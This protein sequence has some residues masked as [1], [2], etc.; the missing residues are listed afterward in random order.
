MKT[1]ETLIHFDIASF[2]I[3]AI[4]LFQTFYRKMS[5]GTT[6][7]IFVLMICT[8]LCAAFFEITL[9]FLRSFGPP[10]DKVL[11]IVKSLY[12]LC[13]NFATPVYLMYVI[14]LTRTWHRFG[15]RPIGLAMFAV[16][17]IVDIVLIIINLFTGFMFHYEDNVEIKHSMLPLYVCAIIY[18]SF[19][20]GYVIYHN[21]LLKKHEIYALASMLP[22]CIAAVIVKNFY[23]NSLVEIFSNTL[24]ILIM[25]MSI[26]RPEH[27]IDS[28]TQLRKYNAY[29]DDMKKNFANNNHFTVILVNIANYSSIHHILGYDGT[30]ELLVGIADKLNKANEKTKA[31]AEIYYLDRGRY[32]VSVNSFN[33]EKV[34]A[35]AEEVNSIFKEKVNINHVAIDLKDHV[36]V[37]RCP[38]DI[39]DFRALMSF[40]NDFHRK[41]SYTGDVIYAEELFKQKDFALYNELD[42]IIDRAIDNNSLK[43]YYQPIYSIKEK[44]FVSAE[45][46]I[47][48]IDKK[49]GFVPPDIFIP[50]AENNGAIHKIGSFVLDQVCSFIASDEFRRLGLEYIEINLSVAQCMQEGLA[51]EVID[52]LQRYNLSPSQINLEITETAASYNQTTMTENLDKLYSA[53]ISFSLDDFG[54][55][56]SNMDRVASLPI[57]IVKLDRSFVNSQH[58]PKTKIFLEHII[59]MFKDMELEIVVEGIESQKMVE[60]F[61]ELE[62]DFIQGYY[63]S[64][65]IPKDEFISF[66]E[67][68]IRNAQ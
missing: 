21:K 47:R 28:F 14:S 30:K 27:I 68:S 31:R 57:K 39:S 12:L 18:I 38:E 58:K 32:R 35:M 10:D 4:T 55:G 26:Q 67:K 25:S 20:M 19:S 34:K 13:H 56:Y 59:K 36:C 43:V 29:A 49:H 9:I 37:V 60:R 62:C 63:F 42:A 24:G 50:A 33:S 61:T 65:P 8:T 45:A 51:E 3:L 2:F 41:V 11:D 22:L 46:L 66:I 17:F 54:T 5:K 40:G 6:N 53:G 7:R 48:L 44:R 15:K 16:P 23:P 52:T 64:K 1:M